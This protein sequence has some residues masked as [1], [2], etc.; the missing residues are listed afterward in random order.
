MSNYIKAEGKNYRLVDPV[1]FAQ[2]KEGQPEK[3]TLDFL[4]NITEEMHQDIRT[5]NRYKAIDDFYKEKKEE[6][7]GQ[8]INAYGPVGRFILDSEELVKASS[9]HSLEC[10]QITVDDAIKE[11]NRLS[12][13]NFQ[14]PE[15]EKDSSIYTKN[16]C[17]FSTDRFIEKLKKKGIT[18]YPVCSAIG[19]NDRKGLLH[20]HKVAVM[21]FDDYSLVVSYSDQQLNSASFN[22]PL[23]MLEI[24]S[25][26]R[27]EDAL[28]EF[29][30]FSDW[31]MTDEIGKRQSNIYEMLYATDGPN[32]TTN[33]L[34]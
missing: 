9:H 2:S 24:P 29:Y 17:F 28:K 13:D 21:F 10:F 1:L 12:S 7:E 5:W 31:D 23:T 25:E 8:K 3:D 26:N 6:I 18:E 19:E 4:V 34:P 33:S 14:L 27:V 22:Q 20:T 30:S 32:E 16:N 11:Y 15:E